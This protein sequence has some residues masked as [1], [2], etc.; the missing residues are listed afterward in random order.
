MALLEDS[1]AEVKDK[2]VKIKSIEEVQ[3]K[4]SYVINKVTKLKRILK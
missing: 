2:S 3:E 4:F 1:L